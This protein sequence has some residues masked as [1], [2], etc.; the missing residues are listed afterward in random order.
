MPSQGS[1]SNLIQQ[2]KTGGDAAA[3]G[4]WMRYFP[5]LLELARRKLSGVSRC[6]AD[7][8]DVVVVAFHSFL[9]RA[10]E[11][12][13]PYLTDRGGLW[14]LLATITANKA[15]NHV[16]SEKSQKRGGGQ[17]MTAPILSDLRYSIIQETLKNLESTDPRP[18]A[19]VVL[20]DSLDYLL[21]LLVDDEMRVIALSKLQG[22]PN[23][24][25]A[26]LINRS[27][28]TVER[29]LK[30]IRDEWQQELLE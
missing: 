17:V 4:L 13:F 18:E 7:E 5:K 23:E 26:K 6:M 28:P 12:D 15:C 10:K 11:G 27:V 25:V 22:L 29:R 3:N 20:S 24:E 8:E 14:R 2:V 16:R 1:V 30:L 19:R 21:S 9:R